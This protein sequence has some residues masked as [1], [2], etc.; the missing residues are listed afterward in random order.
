MIFTLFWILISLSITAIA[1]NMFFFEILEIT[2]ILLF[3][4]FLVLIL[5]IF[6]ERDTDNVQDYI[7][8]KLDAIEKTCE[9]ILKKVFTPETAERLKK[10]EKEIVKWLENF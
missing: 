5:M 10:N 8:M 1:V 4:D 3:F 9:L 2:I 7:L 6:Y